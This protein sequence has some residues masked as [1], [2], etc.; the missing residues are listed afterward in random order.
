MEIKDPEILLLERYCTKAKK[1]GKITGTQL[2]D[3]HDKFGSRFI[4]AWECVKD[5]RIKRYCFEP[6]G[7]IVW[8]VVGRKR[9]Y[10]IMPKA[11][12]CSCDDFYY[13]DIDGEI[14]LCYH[15]IAQKISES[16]GLYDKIKEGD[17]FYD[18]L[19]RELRKVTL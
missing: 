6:S 4:K 14:H 5:R 12:F 17:Y 1:N 2:A 15:L 9:E 19:I 18:I 16:L 3:L 11:G 13:R 8:I 10:L 7:R